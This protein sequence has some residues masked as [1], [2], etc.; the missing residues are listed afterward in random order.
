MINRYVNSEDT[1]KK[2]YNEFYLRINPKN[3]PSL[4]HSREQTW[5]RESFEN[6]VE[7]Q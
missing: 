7:E 5:S 3:F 4:Q 6:R 2:V 1:S